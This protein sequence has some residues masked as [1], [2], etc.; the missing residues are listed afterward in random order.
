MQFWPFIILA[1]IVSIVLQHCAREASM[2]ML[3]KLSWAFV[4]MK[5]SWACS[6]SSHAHVRVKASRARPQLDNMLPG[7][8]LRLRFFQLCCA[9]SKSVFCMKY[10][11]DSWKV[12]K[13]WTLLWRMGLLWGVNTRTEFNKNLLHQGGRGRGMYFRQIIYRSLLAI[14]Y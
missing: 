4:L 12:I 11:C 7:A 5:A 6:W 14:K 1:H 9:W 13:V 8:C 10:V 2:S 3:M